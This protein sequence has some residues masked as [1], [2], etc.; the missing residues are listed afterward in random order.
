MK[1]MRLNQQQQ[2]DFLAELADMPEYLASAFDHLSAEQKTERGADGSFSP[3]EHLWHLADL[4]N[5][6]FA[7]RIRRLLDEVHPALPD[8]EGGRIAREGNYRE[9][10]WQTGLDAFRAT[11]KANLERL[12]RLTPDQ[13]QRHGTLEGVGDISLCDLPSLMAEHD[14]AHRAEIHDWLEQRS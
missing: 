8:F 1:Y 11:R 7:T 4:E 14:D 5:M 3:I 12:R 13:W 2:R 9:R 10:D 6:G